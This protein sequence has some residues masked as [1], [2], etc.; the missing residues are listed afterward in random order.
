M[1]RCCISLLSRE[2]LSIRGVYL[3]PLSCHSY[4]NY[5]S[6]IAHSQ[7]VN[8]MKILGLSCRWIWVASLVISFLSCAVDPPSAVIAGVEGSGAVLIDCILQHAHSDGNGH[9]YPLADSLVGIPFGSRPNIPGREAGRQ[10]I[11]GHRPALPQAPLP[12]YDQSG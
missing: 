2:Y 1:V 3:F 8:P 6:L 12:L 5:W 9:T 11:S 4:N 10:C 7:N